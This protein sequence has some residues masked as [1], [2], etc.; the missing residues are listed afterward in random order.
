MAKITGQPSSAEL[1]KTLEFL[2]RA[3]RPQVLLV[4][5]HILLCWSSTDYQR[6]KRRYALR[7]PSAAAEN[8]LNH[9]H[10]GSTASTDPADVELNYY[11]ATAI[12]QSWR[13][14]LRDV[15]APKFRLFVANEYEAVFKNDG[16][17]LHSERITATIRL[18][19]KTPESNILE[20]FYRPWRAASSRV[21]WPQRQNRWFSRDAVLEFMS[22]QE[23]DPSKTEVL[24]R[25]YPLA[26]RPQIIER[27]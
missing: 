4:R 3:L 22:L 24:S 8:T 27:S 9:F 11:L 23:S 14:H 21:F 6:L 26:S 13:R 17:T 5:G 19:T 1:R 18:W 20:E 12:A 25:W 7:P 2:R 15:G 10:V 16:A